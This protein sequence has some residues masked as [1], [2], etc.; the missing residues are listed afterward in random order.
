MKKKNVI[1]R[2][3]SGANAKNI[4]KCGS[5]KSVLEIFDK[6]LPRTIETDIQNEK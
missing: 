4:K 2:Y 3:E 5:L 6:R 1:K